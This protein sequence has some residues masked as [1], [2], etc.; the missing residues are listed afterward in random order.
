MKFIKEIAKF[1]VGFMPWI[2]FLFIS[3]NSLTSLER[4]IIICFI[5]SIVFGIRELRSGFILQWGTLFFFVA[6]LLAVN[7]LKMT[8]VAENMGLLANGFLASIIW[9][10]VLAGKPFTLQYARAELPKERWH[11]LELVKSC[12]FIAIVWGS[13]LTFSAGVSFFRAVEPGRYPAWCYACIS[14]GTI[15]GGTIFTQVYKSYKRA[16]SQG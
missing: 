3:G 1:L 2:L 10:T 12:R 13:L 6:C 4:A 15:I 11:D 7:V 14:I 5:A 16:Q 8:A 9:L